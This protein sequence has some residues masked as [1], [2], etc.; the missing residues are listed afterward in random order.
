MTDAVEERFRSAA[1]GYL[2]LDLY[3][4]TEDS[5]AERDDSSVIYVIHITSLMMSTP[6]DF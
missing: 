2:L 1:P 3:H 6:C 4:Y 5:L